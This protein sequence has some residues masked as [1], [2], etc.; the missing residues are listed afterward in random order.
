VQNP[1]RSDSQ[2]STGNNGSLVPDG[3]PDGNNDYDGDGVSNLAEFTAGTD[4]AD[5]WTGAAGLNLAVTNGGPGTNVT[6]SWTAEPHGV[7]EVRWSADLVAWTPISSGQQTAGAAG[8]TMTWTDS[9]PPH[10]PVASSATPH[11]FYRVE[12]VR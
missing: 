3:V 12:R 11:R 8:G 2:D 4:P 7:Y 5:N 1:F 10:T 9:G 6:L